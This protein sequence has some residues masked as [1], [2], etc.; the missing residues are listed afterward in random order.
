MR[1]RD[2]EALK[3][4]YAVN[5]DGRPIPDLA[6]ALGCR[7]EP[8]RDLLAEVRGDLELP[9]GRL[10]IGWWAP[11]EEAPDLL[12]RRL[13]LS[14]YLLASLEGVDAALVDLELHRLELFDQFSIEAAELKERLSRGPRGEPTLS[15]PERRCAADEL[16]NARAELHLTGLFRAAGTIFD[17]LA[18]AIVIV[19]ALDLRARRAAW[20]DVTPH[21]ERRRERWSGRPNPRLNL[22][23]RYPSAVAAGPPGWIAWLLDYRNAMVHRGRRLKMFEVAAEESEILDRTGRAFLRARRSPRLAS[24]PGVSDVECFGMGAD[25]FPV[26]E[27]DAEV[28]LTGMFLSVKGLV[29][30][31]CSGLIDVWQT[32]RSDP[33]LMPQPVVEQWPNLELQPRHEFKGFAPGSM[34]FNPSSWRLAPGMVRRMQAAA[35]MDPSTLWKPDDQE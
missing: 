13:V 12:R 15:V 35:L 19:A 11:E 10:G 23:E 32:R 20:G 28:T 14:D 30:E 26:L 4:P 31:L 29:E 17:R 22:C 21:L 9:P 8:L 7:I 16:A 27:E 1:I 24:H 3:R 18:S 34:P 6:E 33:E 25:T 5:E 2:L